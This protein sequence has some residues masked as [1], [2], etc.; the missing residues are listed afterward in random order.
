MWI[1]PDGD[2]PPLKAVPFFPPNPWPIGS[3]SQIAHL[4]D[5]SPSILPPLYLRFVTS[6]G[7]LFQLESGVLPA[8]VQTHHPDHPRCLQAKIPTAGL[9]RCEKLRSGPGS[10]RIPMLLLASLYTGKLLLILM[11]RPFS[12]GGYP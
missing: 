3:L 4:F 9:R 7:F 12:G 6:P 8:L 11:G 10:Q 5:F 1:L 2:R